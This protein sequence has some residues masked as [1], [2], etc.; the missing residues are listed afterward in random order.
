MTNADT[1]SSSIARTAKIRE[2]A[3]RTFVAALHELEPAQQRSVVSD[4]MQ[5]NN[6]E[7]A[8]GPCTTHI[9][10]RSLP[11]LESAVIDTLQANA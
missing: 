8:V 6:L 11:A 3:R 7:A 9:Q 10:L 2:A 4:I 5:A 1:S